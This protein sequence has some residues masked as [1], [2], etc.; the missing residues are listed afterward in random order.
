MNLDDDIYQY[1]FNNLLVEGCN[2]RL[3]P[4]SGSGA[5][6]QGI[7]EGRE[8]SPYTLVLFEHALTEFKI[9]DIDPITQQ[10]STRAKRTYHRQFIYKP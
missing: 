9:P 10:V 7:A 6:K 5:A 8:A 4:H 1:G 3:A 2:S